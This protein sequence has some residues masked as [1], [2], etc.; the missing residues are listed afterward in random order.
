MRHTI[1]CKNKHLAL[2]PNFI[3]CRTNKG[4]HSTSLLNW[5]MEKLKNSFQRSSK[6]SS[7]LPMSFAD[8]RCNKRAMSGPFLMNFA[9]KPNVTCN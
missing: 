2:T 7:K 9:R 5:K 1:I 3:F 6:E 4:Q 8:R